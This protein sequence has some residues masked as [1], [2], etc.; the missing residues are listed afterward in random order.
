MDLNPGLANT[1]F[2]LSALAGVVFA[3]L[4]VTRK[5]PIYSAFFLVLFFA[6][7]SLDFLLLDASFLAFMQM[8]VYAGAIMVLYL[9]VIML[10]NPRENDLPEEGTNV[11]R[12]F[13]AG[14]SMGLFVLLTIGLGKSELVSNWEQSFATMPPPPPTLIP[15][16][17]GGVKSVPHGSIEAFGQE[18]FAEHLFVF[19]LT[20]ILILIAIVGAVH[21]SIRRKAS[22]RKKGPRRVNVIPDH[23]RRRREERRKE[24]PAHV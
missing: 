23:V 2:F 24:R 19:E 14:M 16:P 3:A 17:T 12:L 4:M 7:I 1:L 6:T 22:V 21:L 10:I 5:N 13:A 20:S 8:L 9:F 11:D 18:L 15:G